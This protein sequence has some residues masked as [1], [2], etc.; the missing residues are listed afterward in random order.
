[1]FASSGLVGW[2][3]QRLTTGPGLIVGRKGNVGSLFWSE[4]DFFVIDTAYFVTT[5]L[6]LRFFY[7]DLQCKN[8]INGDAAVPGL[9]RHQAYS[10][11]TVIPPPN[12]IEQFCVLAEGFLGPASLLRR[13]T[14]NLRKTRDLLLPRLLSGQLTVEDAV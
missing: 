1:M 14:D 8:F 9:S 3:D 12:L 13:E 2:H 5:R 6:P 10:L 7:F 4:T 11:E